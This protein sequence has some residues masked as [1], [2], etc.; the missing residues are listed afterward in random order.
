MLQLSLRTCNWSLLVQKGTLAEYTE[1]RIEDATPKETMVVEAQ[2]C[3]VYDSKTA[4]ISTPIQNPTTTTTPASQDIPTTPFI[5]KTLLPLTIGLR[6][7]KAA[8]KAISDSTKSSVAYTE[9]L[10][11]EEPSTANVLPNAT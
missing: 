11:S 8:T 6:F 3:V 2:I 5:A 1:T 4:L 10:P 7:D 9:K